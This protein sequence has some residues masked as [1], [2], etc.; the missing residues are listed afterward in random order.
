MVAYYHFL[1]ENDNKT[2]WWLK[3]SE[4]HSVVSDSGPHGLNSPWNSPGQNTGVGS[5]SLLQGIFPTQGWNLGL[6]HFRIFSTSWATREA[7]EYWSGWLQ[8]I[9]P[10]PAYLPDPEM[11]LEAGRFFT[12]WAT[13]EAL[14]YFQLEKK[15]NIGNKLCIEKDTKISFK[16]KGGIEHGKWQ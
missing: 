14:I 7:Q 3:W 2:V 13:R 9:F 1:L 5:P 10:S 11:K 8:H 12:N 16:K 15:L 4:S 6:L